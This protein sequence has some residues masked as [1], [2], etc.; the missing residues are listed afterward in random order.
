MA[1]DWAGNMARR[2][3]T[4]NQIHTKPNTRSRQLNFSKNPPLK[5]KTNNPI[6]K[7][8][9]SFPLAWRL[10]P[11][12]ASWSATAACWWV[13]VWVCFW[14]FII[15]FD[16]PTPCLKPTKYFP[17]R[18]LP[19]YPYTHTQTPHHTTTHSAPPSAPPTSAP[20]ASATAAPAGA[21]PSPSNT[22]HRA[23]PAMTPTPAVAVASSA[24]VVVGS[25]ARRRA[26]PG[27]SPPPF[28]CAGRRAVPLRCSAGG[29]RRCACMTGWGKGRMPACPAWRGRTRPRCCCCMCCRRWLREGRRRGSGSDVI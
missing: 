1:D 17:G 22:S 6:K 25:E 3:R 12:F 23:L 18:P 13:L 2:T 29:W 19:P 11:G 7:T 24:A 15:Y 4:R 10:G 27:S 20:S 21:P 26:G 8:G 16:C 14:W 28:R 5:H 9:P